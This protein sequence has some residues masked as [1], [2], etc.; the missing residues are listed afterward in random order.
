MSTSP[1]ALTEK[2]H[3]LSEEQIAEVEDFVEFLRVRALDRG[4]TRAAAAL[5]SPS[6]EAVWD[7]PEDAAYD[8]L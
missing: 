3:T 5:S 8:A 7:N 6:F 1:V 4:M 2:I